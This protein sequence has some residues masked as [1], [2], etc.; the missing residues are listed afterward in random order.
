MVDSNLE[1]GPGKIIHVHG[2][3]KMRANR[4]VIARVIYGVS[5]ALRNVYMFLL[6]DTTIQPVVGDEDIIFDKRAWPTSSKVLLNKAS[7]FGRRTIWNYFRIN[8]TAFF[9]CK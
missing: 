1:G 7:E 3:F 8:V 4:Y 5:I 2:A 9:I 6:S